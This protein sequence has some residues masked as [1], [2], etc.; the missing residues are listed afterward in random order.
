M[1][2]EHGSHAPFF[3]PCRVGS[4]NPTWP[5]GQWRVLSVKMKK[6]WS[7]GYSY[8]FKEAGVPGLTATVRHYEGWNVDNGSRTRKE[9]ENNL[10]IGYTVPEGRL[11]G[12]GLQWMYIDV[13][14]EQ[15]PG[16]MDLEEHRIATI[17]TYKF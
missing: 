11:K 9:D 1:F 13:N 4:R 6:S 7:L 12:L 14:Y 3:Q 17:Y 2:G 15:I 5:T 8:D 10:I 16:F